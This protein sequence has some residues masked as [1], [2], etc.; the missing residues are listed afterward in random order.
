MS[1]D[2]PKLSCLNMNTLNLKDFRSVPITRNYTIKN[3]FCH[4]SCNIPVK[5]D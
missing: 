5:K 4:L 1:G 3:I 2:E